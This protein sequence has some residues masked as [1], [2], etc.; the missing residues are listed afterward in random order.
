MI[1][2]A[3]TEDQF[4]EQYG[5]IW[6]GDD[7][8]RGLP[9][10]TGPAYEWDPDSTYVREPPFFADGAGG[11][12]GD[13]EVEGTRVDGARILVKVGDSITTDHISPAGAIRPDSPPVATSSNEVCSSATST[14]TARDEGT[15]R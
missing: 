14:P 6:E 11:P 15:T 4:L 9:T 13:A 10:P 1:A 3:V 5:R 12:V 8:W 2:T 7:R